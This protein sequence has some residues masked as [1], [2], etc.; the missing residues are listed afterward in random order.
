MLFHSDLRQLLDCQ[1]SERILRMIASEQAG[2]PYELTY[3]SS[4]SPPQISEFGT[5]LESAPCSVRI[6]T[7][8]ETKGG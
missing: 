6:K 7:V 4:R 8:S 3:R 1:Q 5:A 2:H